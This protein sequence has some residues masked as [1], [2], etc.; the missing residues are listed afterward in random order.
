MIFHELSRVA[1]AG[2]WWWGGGGGDVDVSWLWK[3]LLTWT[4]M[5]EAKIN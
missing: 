1:G 5:Y 4:H 2:G 3:R